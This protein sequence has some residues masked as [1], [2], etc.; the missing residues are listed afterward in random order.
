MCGLVTLVHRTVSSEPRIEPLLERLAHRGPDDHGWLAWDGSDCRLGR[1]EPVAP[2]RVVMG[3]QRLAIIDLSADGR[4]PM[5]SAD[6]KLYIDYNGEVYNYRELRTE[7]ES[8]GHRFHTHTDTE[9]VLTALRQWGV[10][11]ARRFKGMFAFTLLD[12]ERRK[13]YAVRDH[14]GIKPLYYCRFRDGVGFASE[15][16]PLLDLPG[17]GRELNAQATYDYLQ[18]GNT[19]HNEGTLFSDVKQVPPASI[20]EIDLDTL[21]IGSA[22]KYWQLSLEEND[23][24]SYEQATQRVRDLF[25]ENVRLHLR[26]DVPL[27]AAL[28]GG[29]D[30]SAI[31]CAIRALD[32][33]ADIRTI[34]YIAPGALSEEKWIDM[35]NARAGAKGV[36]IKPGAEDLARDLD[37]LIAMQGEPFGS[38]SIYAQYCVFRAAAENG[39]KV[40]LDGQ[41]ADE[42]L[43]GYPGYQGSVFAELV[44]RKRLV[45]AIRFLN[46]SSKWP[47]RNR[48]LILQLA[49]RQLFPP[50]VQALSRKAIGK[51]LKPDWMNVCWFQERHVDFTPP[52]MRSLSNH[53][54]RESLI[55]TL[56]ATSLPALLRYEDRNSMR[57][58]IESRV[59]FLTYD[60]AELL[61]GLP[62]EYLVDN[63]G[64][65]KHI[66]RQAMR[67]I[68][69]D[70]ILD[71]RD[72][73]GFAT[74]EM[75][76]MQATSSW[77][78]RTLTSGLPAKSIK[79]HDLIARWESS[80]NGRMP[81]PGFQL[82]RWL[83]F[84]RW[85]QVFSVAI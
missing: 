64:G 39:I 76:W 32:S 83:N 81:P 30:S 46:R 82:W 8:L 75:D 23:C 13:L 52:G 10:T 61:V 60:F 11:A 15:I 53:C 69:P 74:S 25:L 44:K 20:L 68:V 16:P 35:A 2:G 57:F 65:S 31:V 62:T 26:S 12:V 7:L 78:D 71:R 50:A 19:A 55:D 21:A 17:V 67:G 70:E 14:F 6:R 84:I 9:V 37:N 36:K 1:D 5:A 51:G 79:A 72:K 73:I 41:G 59:P 47:G 54:L 40:M 29:I 43:A 27:G 48:K 42:M 18:F 80:L 28:S 66:F 49:A 77:V 22:Q 58:S 85:S 56:G 3:Q 4:Q 34:S 38:T 24:G 63:T 45:S 33:K